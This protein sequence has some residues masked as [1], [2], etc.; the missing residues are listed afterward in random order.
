MNTKTKNRGFTLV[1]LIVVLVILAILAAILV[2]ALLGYI[3]EAKKKPILLE[4]KEVWTAAQAA[5]SECYGLNEDSFAESCKHT[6]TINGTT[7][8]NLGRISN[9]SLKDE[10][11]YHHTT[12]LNSSKRIA[13]QVL[14]YL[15]SSQKA[16]ARYTFG[17]G[18]TPGQNQRLNNYLKNPTP[19]DVFI[20]FFYDKRG[21]ILALNFGKDGYMVT[22]MEGQ[23]PTIVENGYILNSTP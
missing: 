22:M 19:T 15:D 9:S 7:L 8:R 14:A 10:Q 16:T 17:S 23:E 20:Q 1:E 4:A 5:A 12:N 13:Q 11:T 2:P 3:D 6:C 18:N 21:Q